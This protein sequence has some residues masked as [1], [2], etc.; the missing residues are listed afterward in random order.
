MRDGNIRLHRARLWAASWL[1][2]VNGLLLALALLR[3]DWLE[4]FLPVDPDG[5]SGA[6]EWAIVAVLLV[7]TLA[8]SRVAR[9]EWLQPRAPAAQSIDPD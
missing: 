9:A 8:S 1:S 6:V 2:V 4:G 5:G 3:P 7:L